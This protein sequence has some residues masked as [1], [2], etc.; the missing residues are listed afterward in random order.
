QMTRVTDDGYATDEP[1]LQSAGY[2]RSPGVETPLIKLS[3]SGFLACVKHQSLGEWLVL[4]GITQ[5][6]TWESTNVCA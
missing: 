1:A 3:G 2:R 4:D 5:T 6:T